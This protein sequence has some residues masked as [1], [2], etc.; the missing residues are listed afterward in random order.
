MSQTTNTADQQAKITADIQKRISEAALAANITDHKALKELA[1]KVVI[2]YALR[3][4]NAQ[5]YMKAFNNAGWKDKAKF[6]G[7]S[8]VTVLGLGAVVVVGT[9][10]A[11]NYM[12]KRNAA[13]ANELQ[14]VVSSDP[15]AG[16]DFQSASERPS[17]L[18]ATK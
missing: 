10:A 17:P 14:D 8:A 6:H 15:F 16:S 4:Y 12:G 9:V 11:V 3:D 7:T 1:D 2:E 18:R 13:K 5:S